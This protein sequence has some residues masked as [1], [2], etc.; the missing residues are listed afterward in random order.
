MLGPRLLPLDL[1]ARLPRIV[2][3]R[4]VRGA[5]V[6]VDPPVAMALPMPEL[7]SL[8]LLRRRPPPLPFVAR[9]AALPGQSTGLTCC[10][11]LASQL[12]PG[13]RV[14]RRFPAGIGGAADQFG[15]TGP[16]VVGLTIG[17]GGVGE[18]AE[19]LGVEDGEHLLGRPL[20]R[21]RPELLLQLRDLQETVS[22]SGQ[23]AMWA[24][25]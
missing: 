16:S 23:P 12:R 11:R 20:R 21:H 24:G 14:L 3:G 10:R 25:E 17:S 7:P 1:P 9:R 4:G 13:Q 18:P 19:A 2:L 6:K 5:R 8:F 22:V 15:G